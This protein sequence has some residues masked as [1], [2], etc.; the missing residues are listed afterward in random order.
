MCR[1]MRRFQKTGKFLQS[2]PLWEFCYDV[3][4]FRHFNWAKPVCHRLICFLWAREF[5][6]SVALD[7]TAS[8][9]VLIPITIYCK[10]NMFGFF[11]PLLFS[12]TSRKASTREFFAS[13]YRRGGRE[14]WLSDLLAY[15][16][17]VTV[18]ILLQTPGTEG[19]S[20]LSAANRK[21]QR[22]L[23]LMRPCAHVLRWNMPGD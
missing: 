21:R 8:F 2:V 1:W 13:V 17:K 14:P 19:H 7:T 16:L 6:M 20:N 11:S 10:C 23:K 4:P 18:S 5:E 3:I 15:W 22:Q 9:A 12:T